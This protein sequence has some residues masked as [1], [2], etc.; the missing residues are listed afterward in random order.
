M[1]NGIFN[2]IDQS[3]YCYNEDLI[4]QRGKK[5][6]RKTMSGI[7]CML[8]GAYVAV[9]AFMMIYYSALDYARFAMGT[10]I[11][12][13]SLELLNRIFDVVLYI[14]QLAVP[15][16]IYLVL[17]KR[18]FASCLKIKGDS[19]KLPFSIGTLLCF[20]ACGFAFACTMS[21]LS[22]IFTQFLGLDK[23][24]YNMPVAQ[25][26]V[27]FIIDFISI[28]LLPPLIEE[29]IFRG[30]ILS[31]LMPYGKSFA[32]VG[33]AVFF[34][35][36]HGSIE[37][38]MYSFVYGVLFAY[39]TV[40]TGSVLTA[41]IIHFLNNAYSCSLDYVEV[42][43]SP[44]IFYLYSSLSYVVLLAAGIICA[45][46]LIGK[47]KIQISEGE[48]NRPVFG[49]LTV[50][51]TFSAFASPIMIIYFILVFLETMSTYFR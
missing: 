27:E 32:I 39:I 6:L 34:A 15:G 5:E 16:I 12:D 35:S 3:G 29:F 4:K 17:R 45:I 14:V 26:N 31:E 2:N 51:E 47:N 23:S 19:E 24:V 33:S 7:C 8:L 9:F 28:A 30:I 22:S 13:T 11:S 50:R 38:M 40:K 20:A 37:Q 44:E 43:V 41:V 18:S 42:L 1:N 10:G 48:E 49:K 46:Y 36:V 21:G 25:N